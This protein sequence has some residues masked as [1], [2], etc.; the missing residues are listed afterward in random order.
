VSAQG[1][2]GGYCFIH[3]FLKQIEAIHFASDWKKKGQ[4]PGGKKIKANFARTVYQSHTDV[5]PPRGQTELREELKAFRTFGSS[6]CRSITSQNY[7]LDMYQEVI[8][9]LHLY[10][11]S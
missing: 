6:Q 3:N 5:V 7:L 10:E 9:F 8:L 4:E 2:L 11:I 1:V